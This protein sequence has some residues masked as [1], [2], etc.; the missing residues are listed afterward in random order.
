MTLRFSS[1]LSIALFNDFPN[2]SAL[3]L[4]V[5]SPKCSNDTAIAKYSPKLSQRKWPSFKNCSTCFGADPPAPNT[6]DSDDDE[7][8]CEYDDDGDD[9]ADK[10]DDKDDYEYDDGDD[11]EYDNDDG[12]NIMLMKLC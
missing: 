11:D 10:D 9:D 1:N 7:N 4:P 12:D 8:K 6:N 3:L 5:V 2:N